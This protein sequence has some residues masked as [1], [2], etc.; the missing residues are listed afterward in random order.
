MYGSE[1]VVT[2]FGI[3]NSEYKRGSLKPTEK[4]ALQVALKDGIQFTGYGKGSE[5]QMRELR[6][7]LDIPPDA[8]SFDLED[9]KTNFSKLRANQ[10]ALVTFLNSFPVTIVVGV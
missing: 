9:V 8:N 10:G 2:K 1:T 6:E 3:T 4:R 7:I 5:S